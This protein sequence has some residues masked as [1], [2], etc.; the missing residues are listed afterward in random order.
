MTCMLG[1]SKIIN[2]ELAGQ[3]AHAGQ[4]GAFDKLGVR[5]VG[6]HPR[7]SQFKPGFHCSCFIANASDD[8]VPTSVDGY[9]LSWRSLLGELCCNEDAFDLFGLS[10]LAFATR[11][12]SQS[13]P[14]SR[15]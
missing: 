3:P 14:A 4:L 8:F 11:A 2:D 1:S 9:R 12:D 7:L 6:A 13:R 10:L 5:Y 15:E